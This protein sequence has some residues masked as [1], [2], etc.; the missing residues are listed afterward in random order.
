MTQL[1]TWFREHDAGRGHVEQFDALFGKYLQEV[2]HVVLSDH[3]VRQRYEGLDQVLLAWHWLPFKWP[4]CL[5]ALNVCAGIAV[6][7][8]LAIN[9]R[10]RHCTD[11]FVFSER[12]RSQEHH[13][14]IDCHRC[15]P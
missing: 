6:E 9:N 8:Q 12:V 14:V 4:D 13:G 2:D 3:C 7:P 5:R 1:P 10:V 15:L 11:R